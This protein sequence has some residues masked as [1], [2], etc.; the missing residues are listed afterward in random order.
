M[1]TRNA[2]HIAGRIL[3]ELRR[4]VR[5]LVLFT[6]SPTFVMV[7]AGGI[8]HNHPAQFDRIGLILLGLFPA[9]PTFV[10]VAFAIQRDR[11]HGTLEYLMTTPARRLDVLT[12]YI[13]AFSLPALAQIGLSVA[14][15]YGVLDLRSAGAWW[16]TGL[17]ALLSSVLGVAMGLFSVNL[18]RNESQLTR[19]VIAIGTPHV[20]LSGIFRPP[21][22]MVGWMHA[23]SN[24]APWRYVVGAASELQVHASPT[25]ALWRSL[26][27]VAAV[28]LLLCAVSV[29][30]VLRRRS[31]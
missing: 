4:D 26:G 9:V 1:V 29:S 8:L 20:M 18:A 24:V 7:L 19:I 27:V 30:T 17:L 28:V 3:R 25:A 11:H 23:L 2:L 21:D 14:V 5:T 16:Q 6:I 12:G 15:T 13:A 22:E 10:F 31:A